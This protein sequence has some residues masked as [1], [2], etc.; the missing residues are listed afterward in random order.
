MDKAP[1][2]IRRGQIWRDKRSGR[3][4]R[5]VRKEGPYWVYRTKRKKNGRKAPLVATINMRG[6]FVLT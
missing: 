1:K 2:E 6:R 5:I 4:V 3:M